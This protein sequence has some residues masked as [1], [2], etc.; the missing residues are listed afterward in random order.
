MK[1]ITTLATAALFA[2]VVAAPAV[3]SAQAPAAAPAAAEPAKPAAVSPSA[4][5]PQKAPAAKVGEAAPEFELPVFGG[6]S[7]FK[8]VDS[9]GKKAIVMAVTQ[10]ACTSCRTELELLNG[11]VGK[12][13]N[14]EIYAVTVDAMGGKDKWND[15]M[16]K[17][18]DENGWKM[19]ILVDPKF[20]VPRKFGVSATPGL[21]VIGKDGI[22]KNIE[23]G[24]VPDEDGD[25]LVKILDSLK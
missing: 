3:V 20:S 1:K 13:A 12:S 15:A 6:T 4:A 2:A 7:V 8:S 16:T 19:P 18:V 24:F 21:V 25:K 17:I 9:K 5:R 10:S 14:F 22:I 11:Y 23:I